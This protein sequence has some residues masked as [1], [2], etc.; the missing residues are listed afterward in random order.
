MSRPYYVCWN[1]IDRCNLACGFCWSAAGREYRNHGASSTAE[2]KRILARMGEIGIGSVMFTGGEP[3]L[4]DDIA[5]LAAESR[6]LGFHTFLTTNGLEA[7]RG[8]LERLDPLLDWLALSIDGSTPEVTRAMR[9]S[10]A[11]FERIEEVL[12][13]APRSF[14]LKINTVVARRN[15]HDI[16][17]IGRLLAGYSIDRWKLFPFT[18]IRGAVPDPASFAISRAEFHAAVDGL[19]AACPALP[20]EIASFDLRNPNGGATDVLLA[21]SRGLLY[22]VQVDEYREIGHVF[23]DDIEDRLRS[24]LPSRLNQERALR[25]YDVPA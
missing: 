11:V 19:A 1:V 25:S 3:L 8:V 20:I 17:A 6:R 16:Q 18:E 7:R 15:A 2:A 13:H 5:E 22:T 12:R 24:V 14:K 10:A 21:T 23:D 4:R 9:G